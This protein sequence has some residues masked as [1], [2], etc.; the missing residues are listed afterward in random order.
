MTSLRID[1]PLNK[2]PPLINKQ[3]S[4]ASLH[5]KPTPSPNWDEEE[6]KTNESCH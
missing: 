3:R 6:G 5:R 4:W 2:H 1:Q